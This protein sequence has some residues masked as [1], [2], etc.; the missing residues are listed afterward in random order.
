MLITG[1][2]SVALDEKWLPLE[3]MVERPT[4][5]GS[6]GI[7]TTIGRK[8]YRANID[9]YL[10]KNPPGSARFD[11]LLYHEQIHSKRQLKMGL[12]T[13]LAKY[14]TDIEFMLKEE[15]LGYYAALHNLRRRGMSRSAE[16]I[17]LSMSK[18]K[19]LVGSMVS[20][21][22]ALAWARDMISGRW[23]PAEEDLWSLP[24]WLVRLG[25]S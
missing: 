18:Y 19:N 4:T 20:Y 2:N 3:E 15:Q 21:E 17:A 6:S 13:W 9:A 7:T 22:D 12:A 1:C 8:I 11:S 16:S 23:K 24:E 14:G 5:N 25:H 10:E